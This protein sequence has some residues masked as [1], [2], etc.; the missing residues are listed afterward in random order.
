ML[1][2][3][4]G[5]LP[6]PVDAAADAQALDANGDCVVVPTSSWRLIAALCAGLLPVAGDAASESVDVE[7][8]FLRRQLWPCLTACVSTWMAAPDVGDRDTGQALVA[9]CRALQM[10]A[11]LR[12]VFASDP[13]EEDLVRHG[14]HG[15]PAWIDAD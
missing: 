3:A 6:I 13:S 10:D 4:H 9:V 8:R 2:H 1:R 15:T 7:A 5:I 11:R 14:L 12:H